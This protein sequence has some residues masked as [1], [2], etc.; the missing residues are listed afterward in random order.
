MASSEPRILESLLASGSLEPAVMRAYD[1]LPPQLT[2]DFVRAVYRELKNNPLA[3]PL[4]S[5]ICDRASRSDSPLSAWIGELVC[6]FQWLGDRGRTAKVGDVLEYISC[7]LEGS[8]R[9]SGH[10]VEWYLN[11]YGFERSVPVAR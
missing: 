9:Q 4:L 2:V 11:N 5:D 6:A 10:N 3:G 8:S 7:A 1:S